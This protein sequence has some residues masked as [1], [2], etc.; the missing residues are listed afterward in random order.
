M[1]SSE[2]PSLMLLSGF[3]HEYFLLFFSSKVF[4]KSY[5][6]H[7]LKYEGPEDITWNLHMFWSPAHT[8]ITLMQANLHLTVGFPENWTFNTPLLQIK[9]L[10]LRE[11]MQLSEGHT[12]SRWWNRYQSPGSLAPESI[13]LT[14]QSC[15]LDH[16]APVLSRMECDLEKVAVWTLPSCLPARLLEGKQSGFPQGSTRALFS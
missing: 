13:L 11:V 1:L 7:V 12:I 8:L 15:L 10:G 2:N 6:F 3:N 16:W 5:Y 4:I 14:T 9:K